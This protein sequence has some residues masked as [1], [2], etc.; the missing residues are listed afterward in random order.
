LKEGTGLTGGVGR[1]WVGAGVLAMDGERA[2]TGGA[3]STEG[4]RAREH[5]DGGADKV[6]PQCSMRERERKEVG[7][8]DRKAG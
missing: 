3:R 1:Q 7:R 5:E 6:G 4:E 8:V 2:P